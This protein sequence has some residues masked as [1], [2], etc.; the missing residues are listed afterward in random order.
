MRCSPWPE[1]G[2]FLSSLV[3]LAALGV[4]GGAVPSC[5]AAKPSG[6]GWTMLRLD[7]DVTILPVEQKIRAEGTMTLRLDAD[8]STGPTL[9]MNTRSSV[10]RF[11]RLG[12][13]GDEVDRKLAHLRLAKPASRGAE[14]TVPFAYESEGKSFQF[15]VTPEFALASWVEGWFPAPIPADADGFTARQASAP[16]LTRFH[17]PRGWRSVSNGKL[18]ARNE[19]TQGVDDTWEITQPV[20]RSFIAAPF[21]VGVEQVEGRQIGVYLLSPKPVSA[22]NQAATLAKA[23]AAMEARFGPYPYPSYAIAEVPESAIEWYA[24]SEQGFI[25]AKSSAFDVEG[26]NIPLFAHE[27]AHAW[28]GNLVNSKGPGS[29]L[30]S[31]SLAQY[32]AIVAI[33][34]IEG[35]DKRNEFLRFSRSGYNPLQCA[36]G[37]FQIWRKGGDKPLSQL[38]DGKFDHNLSDSKGHWVYHMLRE[39]VGDDLFFSTLRGLIQNY[40]G[41]E[42]SLDDIRVAFLAT[43]PPETNLNAFFSQWL[44]RTGAPIL[45][46][47]WRSIDNDKAAEIHIT[48]RQP[49]SPYAMPLE[50]SVETL[51][52]ATTLHTLDLHDRE[53]TFT[54]QTT[55]RPVT[56]HLDPNTRSLI[57]QPEYGP[58]P[59]GKQKQE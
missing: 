16:G 40:A 50:I 21:D 7:L 38:A 31:E 47:D 35:I 8:S 30:C 55:D 2:A 56:V 4:F 34:S 48:Q 14:I 22:K 32:G 29:Q 28:W 12:D 1:S 45:D 18:T 11:T 23:L 27:A 17:L 36:R 59:S 49:G 39:R 58:R 57:W 43:A 10:M 6:G 51:G 54:V 44:D 33:E 24:S 37:Y 13:T 52:G 5:A 19:S 3:G 20:A 42:M 9:A 46:L 41:K 53:Q 25:M 26:G 15:M